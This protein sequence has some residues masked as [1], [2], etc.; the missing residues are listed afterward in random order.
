MFMLLLS[1]FIHVC[2]CTS[3]E[4]YL[5]AD[6]GTL[7]RT[8]AAFESGGVIGGGFFILV[9]TLIPDALTGYSDFRVGGLTNVPMSRLI[10]AAWVILLCLALAMTLHNELDV[11][12]LGA[13]TARSLGLPVKAVRLGMLAL[14]CDDS[15]RL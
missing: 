11:L 1:A 7:F 3:D 5:T 8:G 4:A 2:V 10:P 14:A 12:A 15:R 13:D 9:V 6:P